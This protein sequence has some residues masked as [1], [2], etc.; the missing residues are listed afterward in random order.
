MHSCLRGCTVW[1]FQIHVVNHKRYPKK[2]KYSIKMLEILISIGQQWHVIKAYWP[3][4]PENP[5]QDLSKNVCSFTLKSDLVT[6]TQCSRC[7]CSCIVSVHVYSLSMYCQ[8]SCIVSVHVL[9]LFMYCQCSCIVN[10]HV[11]SVFMYCHC[12]CIVSIHVLSV[13][14][15]RR[16]RFKNTEYFFSKCGTIQM[17][18]KH[19]NKNQNFIRGIVQQYRS[20]S[21]NA[22]YIQFRIFLPCL[23]S[24]ISEYVLILYCVV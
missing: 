15:S 4:A 10:V 8:C 12:S 3:S 18:G 2:N 16:I 19:N 21:G 5:V 17:S 24:K 13:R 20:D 22:W 23:L 7:Q 11:L 9:S 14:C 1:D 6:E